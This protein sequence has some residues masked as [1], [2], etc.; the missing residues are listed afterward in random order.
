MSSRGLLDTTYTKRA[1]AYIDLLEKQRDTLLVALKNV[2]KHHV[3]LNDRAGRR[4]ELSATLRIVRDA[5][6]DF[7]STKKG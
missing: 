1:E 5:L 7:C 2:E 3:L 4:Q 6:K